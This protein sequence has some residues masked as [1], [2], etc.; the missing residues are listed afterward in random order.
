MGVRSGGPGV[1]Q[2]IGMV[3]TAHGAGAATAM[4]TGTTMV[5]GTAMITATTV[6]IGTAMITGTTMVTGT[7][8]IAGTTMVGRQFVTPVAA[9]SDYRSCGKM[10]KVNHYHFHLTAVAAKSDRSTTTTDYH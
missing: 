1:I 7:A 3:G 2:K 4:V 10:G 8:M 9:K 6:V 5:T